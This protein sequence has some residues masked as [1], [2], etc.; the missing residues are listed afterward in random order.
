MKKAYLM[1]IA[2]LV[3]LMIPGCW[4]KEPDDTSDVTND[5]PPVIIFEGEKNE[6][7]PA[8]QWLE[9]NCWMV[10]LEY[11]SGKYSAIVKFDTP[12]NPI[13]SKTVMVDGYSFSETLTN[14]VNRVQAEK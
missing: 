10:K 2:F 12:K 14:A 7:P 9:Q 11:V 8:W 6:K 3:V 4:D 13:G 5:T 1:V